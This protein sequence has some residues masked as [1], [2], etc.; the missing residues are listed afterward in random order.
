[1]P[2]ISPKAFLFDFDG[3][4]CDSEKLHM[5]ATLATIKSHDLSFS[6]EYYFEKLFGFDDKALFE[7][8]FE[9]GDKKLS[10]ELLKDLIVKKNKSFMQMI[11]NKV[12]YFD[13]VI[14]LIQK[15][16]VQK[17][18][19]AVVS[20]ALSHEVEHCLVIGDL[21]KYF[22]FTVCADNVMYSKPNPECYE[23][24]YTKM[25]TEVAGLTKK[26]CWVI[27]DSPTGIAAAKGAG[28]NVIGIS[29]TTAKE[30]LSNADCIISHYRE[31]E[32]L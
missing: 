17:I 3:V 2:K 11:Q 15:F 13:G 26:D 8:V 19:I 10:P 1:M 24:A 18:P 9:V 28:L 21:R 27:E 7:H 32:I 23:L 20:G 25:Q 30:K 6:E 16:E 5:W 12:I 22:R 14:D 29:N 31:I 4:I